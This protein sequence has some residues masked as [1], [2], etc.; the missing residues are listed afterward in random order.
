M[1]LYVD[2]SNS[3]KVNND[4]LIFSEI[5]ILPVAKDF[6]NKAVF[7][8]GANGTASHYDGTEISAGKSYTNNNYSLIFT[9][10]SSDSFAD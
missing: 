6:D 1:K 8:L 7:E 9:S 5:S 3:A 2:S 10:V 4:D